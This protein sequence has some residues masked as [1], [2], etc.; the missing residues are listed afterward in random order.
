MIK[1][2]F[3]VVPAP[4]HYGDRCKVVSAH[5]TLDAAKRAAALGFVVRAGSLRK[6][7][8]FTRADEAIFPVKG[9]GR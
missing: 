1:T 5:H 7:T 6:G 2:V 4:G 9:G 8:E 3:F